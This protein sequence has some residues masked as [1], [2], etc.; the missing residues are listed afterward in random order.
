MLKYLLTALLF[1]C[2]ALAAD[3]QPKAPVYA[4][5]TWSGI[6]AGLEGGAN[7]G[8]FS[9]LLGQGPEATEINLDD[10]SAFVGGH[11]GYAVQ[12][13]NLVFGPEVGIQYWDFKSKN[14]LTLGKDAPVTFQQKVDWLAY[15]NA[16][17]GIILTPGVLAYVTG[18]PAWAHTRG[19]LINLASL[20]TAFDQSVFGWN[21][22]AGASYKL[23]ETILLSAEFRHYDFGKVSAANPALNLTGLNQDNLIVNQIMGRVSFRI[24]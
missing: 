3:L 14:E 10:N 5:V 22:G 23:T 2:P 8:K 6:Y 9:P 19:E 17:V 7:L 11:M 20:N 1:V 16:R 24:P 4:P 18:G 13:G 15:V 12:N 21:L